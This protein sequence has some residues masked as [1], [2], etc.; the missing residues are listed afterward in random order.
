MDFLLLGRVEAHGSDHRPVVLGRR[1]ERCLLGLL[2]LNAGEVVSSDRLVSLLWEDDP[3]E[4]PRATLRTYVSRLRVRL[5]ELDNSGGPLLVAAHGGYRAD[6]DPASVD[7]HRFRV[8]VDQARSEREAE[9]AARLLT[10]ALALWRG[11][12]LAD[13]ASGR[14]R[15][16][17]GAD[18]DELRTAATELYIDAEI[19][20][21]RHREVIATLTRLVAEHPL[22]EP[23]V[24]RLMLALHRA[25][26]RADA[27]DAYH[28][29]RARL[30]DATGIDP[31]LDLQHRYLAVLHG[32]PADDARGPLLPAESA[33]RSDAAP[34]TPV[35]A[36]L[37]AV[38]PSFTGRQDALRQ[39]NSLMPASRTGQTVVAVITGTAGVGKTAL[40][41]YWSQSVADQFPD[42]QLY[43]NLRGFDPDQRLPAHAVLGSFLQTLGTDPALIPRDLD[44]R[45]SMF[46]SLLAGQRML[47]LLDNAGT[48]EQVRPLLPGAPGC[49]ALVTSRDDLAGLVVRDGAH[50]LI[51]DRLSDTEAIDLLRRI[52]GAARIDAELSAAAQL[53]PLCAGLP[54]ALSVAAE[55][56]ARHPAVPLVDLVADLAGTGHRLDALDVPGDPNSAVRAVLSWSYRELPPDTARL[57]RLLAMP[58]GSNI[59]CDAASHLIGL[60]RRTTRRLLTELAS[61]HL[62]ENL[63][64]WRYQMHD[65]LRAYAAEQTLVEDT[66]DDRHAAL[67][68]LF[69]WYL[70]TADTAARLLYPDT[71]RLPH[72]PTHHPPPGPFT[73]HADALAW[74]AAEHTNLTTTIS[75]TATHGPQRM[76]WRLYDALRG[77]L[78]QSQ[79]LDDLMRAGRAALT[80][81]QTASHAPAQAIAYLGIGVALRELGEHEQGSRHYADALAAAERAGWREG[82]AGAT[83]NLGGSHLDAGRLRPAAECF[84]Q[85]AAVFRET[86][87]LALA[88]VN[89]GNLG[90]T[91]SEL[92]DMRRAAECYEEAL[93]ITRKADN[94]NGEA[95]ALH[96]L[97]NI[98]HQL[99]RLAESVDNLTN[100][101]TIYQAVGSRTGEAGALDSLA[102]VYRDTGRHPQALVCAEAALA[103]QRETGNQLKTADGLVTLASIHTC[104]GH[105]RQAIGCY[106]EA[107]RIARRGKGQRAEVAALIGLA[108]THTAQGEPEAARS[109]AIS[110]LTISRRAGYR[111]LE[112][113]ALSVLST[114]HRNDNDI[115]QALTYA[116]QALRC[117]REA[118]A[119]LGEA[120][121]LVLL[122][123]LTEGTGQRRP[124]GTDGE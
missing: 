14:L 39:L 34:D 112:A 91:H 88:A 89:L 49:L 115:A 65:L 67:G 32:D 19:T 120:R 72:G 36:Q 90:L 57:F 12:L 54:L 58:P 107:L 52:L 111:A 117:Y 23:F 35:P 92:G 106:R 46:R 30:A 17:V 16:R 113:E 29:L 40:A 63:A 60:D 121:V 93:V 66:E 104:L 3:P 118:G 56:A 2:L 10:D 69:D 53:V 31:G 105:Q 119:L 103:V 68:R 55:R 86:G 80:A 71:L 110:A 96:R 41:V 26:R 51:L 95:R 37:P 21:G 78:Y 77:Y 4:D 116:R 11:P 59:D 24:D 109:L 27:L 75:H 8:L 44:A 114:I 100:A 43:V 9:H 64:P 81:A 20:S 38:I 108:T 82:Y 48:V 1:R 42:G 62:V 124:A 70:S 101:L 94:R 45:S 83:G 76:A 5:A 99:G 50:R 98:Q 6:V 87:H 123:T 18:L 61:A 102:A 74:L 85:A 25:G 33:G 84:A 79:H 15:E 22:H 73:G 47:I 13:V 122:D 28:T 7:V 97:G